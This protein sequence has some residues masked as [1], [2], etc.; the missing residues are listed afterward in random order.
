MIGAIPEFMHES[1]PVGHPKAAD[2]SAGVSNTLSPPVV[3][4]RV[5]QNHAV[6][7]RIRGRS[8]DRAS[9]SHVRFGGHGTNVETRA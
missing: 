3:A 9:V 1:R 4:L 6:I 7:R 8:W 2:L 5:Q